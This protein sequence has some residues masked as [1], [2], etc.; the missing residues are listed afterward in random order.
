MCGGNPIASTFADSFR[1]VDQLARSARAG[2]QV[3]IHNTLAASDY[4][5]LEEHTYA[6]R[7]DYWA[8]LLWKRL[9]GARVLD[10]GAGGD[11]LD[12]Y[13]QCLKDS[14]GGVLLIAINLDAAAP[15]ALALDRPAQ[16][17]LVRQ[18][19]AFPPVPEAG[20]PLRARDRNR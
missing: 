7:P 9:A 14:R 4:G 1:F 20:R 3:F 10:A 19:R 8:A 17:L 12:L 6:P 5:L 11:R 13:G 2:V 18:A 15:R 16:R